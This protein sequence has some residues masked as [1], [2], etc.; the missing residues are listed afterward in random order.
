V[1]GALGDETS[2]FFRLLKDR[3]QVDQVQ[4]DVAQIKLRCERKYVLFQHQEDVIYT[5]SDSYGD[6]RMEVVGK[7]GTT[8]RLIQS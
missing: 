3:F 1:Q 8:F 5:I 4:G 7:R 6:C 2:W